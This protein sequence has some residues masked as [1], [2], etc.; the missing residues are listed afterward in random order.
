MLT[1]PTVQDFKDFFVRDFPY[2]LDV[3]ENVLDADIERAQLEA[4]CAIYVGL[5]GDQACYSMAFNYLSAHYLS[6]N[7]KNSSQGI[8][9]QYEGMMGSKSVGSVSA[10]YQFPNEFIMNPMFSFIGKTGYGA[11]YL[12]ILYPLTIGTVFA[13]SG[14]THA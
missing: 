11:R 9:G 3:N 2:G 5:F 13:V 4:S 14:A 8:S 6:T 12:E 1:N 10:S 7:L